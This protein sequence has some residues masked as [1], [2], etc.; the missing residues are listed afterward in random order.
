M[1]IKEQRD[2]Y[3]IQVIVSATTVN[4][5]NIDIDFE[6]LDLYSEDEDKLVQIRNRRTIFEIERCSEGVKINIFIL[7]EGENVD[8]RIDYLIDEDYEIETAYISVKNK[9]TG[10]E[11]KTTL[12][13]LIGEQVKKE[14][15][16]EIPDEAREAVDYI[17]DSLTEG[18]TSLD[19]TMYEIIVKSDDLIKSISK[20]MEIDF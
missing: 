15:P 5:D 14:V 19:K 11:L 4:V 1:Q 2:F 16:V 10:K 20:I 13:E 12:N 9:K 17:L 6:G 8:E 3:K 7:N 18:N